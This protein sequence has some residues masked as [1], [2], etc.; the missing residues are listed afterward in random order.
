M[1]TV[2]TFRGDATLVAEV[3]SCSI[4]ANDVATTY[5]LTRNG[6]SV[7]VVGQASAT[8]TATALAAAWNLS[9]DGDF[10]EV[11][12]SSAASSVTLT[13]DSEG[14]PFGS[15]VTSSV[16][17]GTGTISAVSVDTPASGPSILSIANLDTGTM[18][19]T[20]D[21]LI[22]AASVVDIKYHLNL[23][24]AV[25]LLLLDIRADAE[26]EIGLPVYNPAGYIEDRPLN[27]Q[28][29]YATTAT[30]GDGTGTGSRRLQLQLGTGTISNVSVL[31][32]SQSSAD[33]NYAPVQLSGGHTTS[34]LNVFSGSVDV[35]PRAGDTAAYGTI[36]ASGGTVRCFED[37]TL[38]TVIASKNANVELRSNTTTLKTLDAGKA[39]VIG[40]ANATT[41]NV[42]GGT[43]TY[44]AAGTI[45]TLNIAAGKTFNASTNAIG[46][47]V[48]NCTATFGATIDDPS[49][50]LTFSNAIAL[51][52]C[53]LQDV[54]HNTK[55]GVSY[56]LS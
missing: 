21:S 27:L 31:K 46:A 10:A 13:A 36:N 9:A 4:T 42:H 3:A 16:T 28:V 44:D 24:S 41:V 40:T 54:T 49:G 45:T 37:V 19:I 43:I 18:P 11:T 5:K 15:L 48:T 34:V 20:G 25:G 22:I 7:S 6:R 8:A 52:G 1:P 2:H 32:T 30:I 35:A 55:Q 53:G 14:V 29:A 26:C 38:G 50:K 51:Q 33:V 23:L 39:S 47:T 17:G 12:A 56:L